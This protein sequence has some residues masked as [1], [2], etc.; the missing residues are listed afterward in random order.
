MKQGYVV[1]HLNND[2]GEWHPN[3]NYFVD[4]TDALRHTEFLR[5]D[6]QN[7][8]VTLA[9]QTNSIVGQMGVSSVK[10]GL[11]PDGTEYTWKKRRI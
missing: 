1:Y 6:P 8:F 5:K 9:S 4:M 11:L 10:D 7:Q 3:F 2:E